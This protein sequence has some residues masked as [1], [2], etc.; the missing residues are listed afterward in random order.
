MFADLVPPSAYLPPSAI[1]GAR[2][3]AESGRR[4]ST[5]NRL[6][7]G[8]DH[9]RNELAA[10]EAEQ[11]AARAHLASVVEPEGFGLALT[12]LLYMATVT[13]GIPM[14]LMVPSPLSLPMWLR[15]VV[16]LLFLSGVALLLRYLFVYANYLSSG[17]HRTSLPNNAW[18]LLRRRRA[19]PPTADADPSTPSTSTARSSRRDP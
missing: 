18:G 5:L 4:Q 1:A 3:A 2:Y 6:I 11:S 14:V 15:A 10:L 17:G 12:V 19:D 16:A 8:R 13:I 9:A 7:E